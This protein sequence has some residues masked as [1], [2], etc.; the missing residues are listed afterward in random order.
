[1]SAAQNEYESF[2]IVV[3]NGFGELKIP[4]VYQLVNEPNKD[5]IKDNIRI[6]SVEKFLGALV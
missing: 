2:Q 5:L 4:F 3:S 6:M 1:M